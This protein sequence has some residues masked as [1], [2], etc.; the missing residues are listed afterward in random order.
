MECSIVKD[1]LQSEQLTANQVV[2]GMLLTSSYGAL[3]RG[4]ESS[5]HMGSNEPKGY[6]GSPGTGPDHTHHKERQK[7]AVLPQPVARFSKIWSCG[8]KKGNEGPTMVTWPYK[9][10]CRALAIGAQMPRAPFCQQKPC[11]QGSLCMKSRG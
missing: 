1:W 5:E 4:K 10:L 11:W 9:L 6:S 2:K 3:P 7:E 8:P